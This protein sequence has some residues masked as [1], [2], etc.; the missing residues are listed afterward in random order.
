MHALPSLQPSPSG[1]AGLEQVPVA[2][3]HVPARWH[4]SGGG[5]TT[6]SA[7]VHAPA[8]QVSVL[9]HA[10]PSLQVA[11]SGRVGFEQTPVAGLHVPGVWH[12][13]GVAHTTGFA[14]VH[15]PAWQVSVRVQAF[16]S[17]HD[18]S[19]GATGFE[20]VPVVGLQVPA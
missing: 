5:Q 11:P 20:H 6:G 3:L 9:V 18:V 16:P 15:T 10:L 14:P 13:S 7:P 19:L 17:L 1:R 2:G 12:W 8:W 4:W